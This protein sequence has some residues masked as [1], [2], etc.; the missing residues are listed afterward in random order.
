MPKRKAW[1]TIMTCNNIYYLAVRL[2]GEEPD[3]SDTEDL[4]RR[5]AALIGAICTSLAASDGKYR[6]GSGLAVCEWDGGELSLEDEFPLVSRYS[7][8]AAYLLASA[9]VLDENRGLSDELNVRGKYEISSIN[10]EIPAS[11]EK[12]TEVYGVR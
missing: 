1:K 10:S 7:T 5:S 6:A 4:R 2:L 12:I 8:G 11:L 3:A 9:L